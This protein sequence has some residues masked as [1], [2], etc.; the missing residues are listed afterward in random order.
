MTAA[1]YHEHR[2]YIAPR[3]HAP[4]F[5]HGIGA[6]KEGAGKHQQLFSCGIEAHHL[7]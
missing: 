6:T 2:L 3:S 5:T 1:D 7:L 4:A